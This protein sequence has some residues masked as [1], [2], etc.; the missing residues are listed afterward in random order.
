MSATL[1]APPTTVGKFVWRDLV[2]TNPEPAKVFYAALFGWE[3]ESMPMPS[4]ATV[5]YAADVP[6]SGY[7]MLANAGKHFGGIVTLGTDHSH[8]PSHWASYITVEN[9]DEAV[10][11][12]TRLGGTVHLQPTDIPNV[13]RFAV[14][15]DPHGAI[16]QPFTPSTGD[17]SEPDG[18]PLIGAVCWNE[19][20]SADPAVAKSFY[21]EVFGWTFDDVD[22][23]APYTII[24]RG[25]VME[26]GLFQKPDEI[27]AS[28]WLIYFQVADLNRTL[29]DVSRLGGQPLHEVIAVPSVGRISWAMDP[30]GAVFALLEPEAR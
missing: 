5:M 21:G 11:A 27:P 25:E 1:A 28:M 20:I 9:V 4:A 29:A 13:G 24:K 17:E 19:L 7:D 8:V 3:I 14:A 16:F 12:I 10:S 2:T 6:A 18:P 15:A 23:G 26:G 30:V 22:M